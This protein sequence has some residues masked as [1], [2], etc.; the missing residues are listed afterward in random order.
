[1]WL[2]LGMLCRRYVGKKSSAKQYAL[3]CFSNGALCTTCYELYAMY[4][5]FLCSINIFL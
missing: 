1:M 3:S 2:Y 5:V 4:V